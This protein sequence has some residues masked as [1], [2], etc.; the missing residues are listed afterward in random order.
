MYSDV[1]NDPGV[2]YEQWRGGMLPR[3][4]SVAYVNEGSV[5]RGETKSITVHV[6]DRWGMWHIR[7]V[8][9]GWVEV[10][11]EVVCCGVSDEWMPV[12]LVVGVEYLP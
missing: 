7:S 5:G 6:V 10:G 1:D 11:G 12:V 2:L 4:V 3:G 8:D 9:V